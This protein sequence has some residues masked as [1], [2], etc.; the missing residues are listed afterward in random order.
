MAVSNY[1]RWYYSRFHKIDEL[2]V[3]CFGVDELNEFGSRHMRKKI[4]YVR[5]YEMRCSTLYRLS[6]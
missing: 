1:R 3:T 6:D 4:F 2:I 5:S